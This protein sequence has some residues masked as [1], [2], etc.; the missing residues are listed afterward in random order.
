MRYYVYVSISGEK[1]ISVFKMA[2]ETGTLTFDG[3]LPNGGSSGPL[4]V[5]P[6]QE[7]LYAAIRSPSTLSSFRIDQRTGSLSCFAEVPVDDDPTYIITDKGGN[8]LLS[9]HYEMGKVGVHPIGR[10]RAVGSPAVEWV[11]TAEKA[12]SISTDPSNRFVFVPHTAGPN[13]IFQFRFDENTGALTPNQVPKVIPGEGEGPRHFCFHPSRD[14]VYFVNEQGGSVT[15]YTLDP[16]AG[17]LT[18]FQTIST[19]PEEYEGRNLCA[20]IRVTP[21]GEFLYASNRGHDSIAC[22]SI[23]A[24]TGRLTSLGQ[25]PTEPFPRAFALDPTGSFLFAAGQVSGNLASY[26]VDARTGKLK[27]LETFPVGKGPSWVLVVGLPD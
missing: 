18:A 15:A 11:T 12:H 5:D 6:G 19:L 4:A 16:S 13:L 14:I 9:A 3:D 22:F 2:P 21:S 17:T 1:K 10:D 8:F 26:R 25:Q 20:E 23:D 7:I 24:S 27:P